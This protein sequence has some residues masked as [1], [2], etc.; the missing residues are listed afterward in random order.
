MSSLFKITIMNVGKVKALV[1]VSKVHPDAG[2]PQNTETFALMLLFDPIFLQLPFRHLPTCALAQEMSAAN[3][4]DAEWLIANACRFVSNVKRVATYTLEVTVTD[5]RWI[6]HL[7]KLMKWETA[8]VSYGPGRP[9]AG[10]G[11]DGSR[12]TQKRAAPR[13]RAARS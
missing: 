13:A 2:K 1:S 8:A 6:A 10:L 5:P 9:I 11:S 4:T 12:P 3:Y 7:R